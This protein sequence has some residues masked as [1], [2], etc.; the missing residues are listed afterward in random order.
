VQQIRST[1]KAEPFINEI[2]LG[3]LGEFVAVTTVLACGLRRKSNEALR[4]FQKLFD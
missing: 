4:V 2:F 3:T 1:G